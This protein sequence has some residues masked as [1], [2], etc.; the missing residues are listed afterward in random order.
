MKNYDKNNTGNRKYKIDDEDI[1]RL[2]QAVQYEIPPIVEDKLN[3][4]LE[5]WGKS[6]TGPRRWFLSWYPAA[7][8]L[9]ATVIIA[10]LFTF[11][12]FKKNTIEPVP[13]SEIR[14]EFE[15]KD[16]NIKII[17]FQKKDFKLRRKQS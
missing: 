2:V 16:K 5:N 10:A 4:D 9:A 15:L 17:W 7:A 11:Q 14:T 8:V 13:I 12:P 3:R 6:K 1:S